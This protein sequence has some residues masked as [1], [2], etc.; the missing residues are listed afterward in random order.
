MPNLP[1][2]DHIPTVA[3]VDRIAALADP[4]IRN[5]QITQC[6][7]ELAVTMALRTEGGANWCTFATWASKQAGQTIRKEDL[8]RMLE[9]LRRSKPPAVQLT[10]DL[11]TSVQVLG[12][13][14]SQVEIQESL[15]EVLD[16]RAAFRR[17][18]DAVGR[19][20]KKVFEEIGREFAR[21][22]ARCLNDATFDSEKIAQFCADLR[23]GEPPDGQRYLQQAFQRYYHAFFESNAKA[24]AELMLLASIEIGF[25]EQMRLQPEIAE[26]MDAA[27]VNRRRFRLRLIKALFPYRGWLARVRLFLLRLLDRPSPLDAL[28]DALLVEARQQAHLVITE[29]LMTIGLPHGVRLRLGRDVPAT[30]PPS[31]QHIAL[32]EL[33]ALLERIDP[34]PDST[35][36]SGA[37]DWASLPDRLHFIIDMFRCYH[38]WPFLF[39]P[40][41]TAEQIVALKAGRRP[42][43]RL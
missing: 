5:L 30:F 17:A 2:I 42:G 7:H 25:H 21:F 18:S 41:F 31:L 8:A 16:P 4:V 43:G 12:S 13:K 35:R 32:P 10:P 33:R 36:D 38:E 28:L 19:G 29:H 37:M 3:E 14:R 1:A 11:I 39:E 27:F 26:A 34:T 6:Y 24:R 15:A 23:P 40:P 22:S 20:N 9:N